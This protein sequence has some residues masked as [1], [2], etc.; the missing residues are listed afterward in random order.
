MGF[1]L[2]T[3]SPNLG[4]LWRHHDGAPLL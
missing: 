4:W 2:E 1:W 3:K